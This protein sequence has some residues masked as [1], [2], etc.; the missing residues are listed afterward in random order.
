MGV[1]KGSW[2]TYLD[3][4]SLVAKQQK[5]DIFTAFKVKNLKQ[6]RVMQLS[7]KIWFQYEVWLYRLKICLTTS[8]M[9]LVLQNILQMH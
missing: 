1:D 5:V 7:C 9:T 6:E 3:R 4:R 8:W 2:P